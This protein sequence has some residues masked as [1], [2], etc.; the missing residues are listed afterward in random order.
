MIEV[1]HPR[2][3]ATF[4]LI[5]A[6]V[7]V[8]FLLYGL[9][10]FV[11]ETVLILCMLFAPAF[12]LYAGTLLIWASAVRW[13]PRRRKQTVAVSIAVLGAHGAIIAVIFTTNWNPAIALTP[14]LS[15]LISIAAVF[16]L[17]LWWYT[18]PQDR[19]EPGL[20]PCPR[21]GYDLRGQTTCRCPECGTEF[22]LGE[23]SKKLPNLGEMQ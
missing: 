2:I 21:C 5:P 22:T 11:N 7:V 23:L 10:W 6:A 9:G 3:G 15:I 14:G 16:M 19:H 8:E 17:N 13:T 12:V 20:V 18:P 1:L 4:L